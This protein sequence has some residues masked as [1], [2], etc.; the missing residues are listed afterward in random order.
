MSDPFVRLYENLVGR[1]D[2]PMQFRLM[3]QPLMA[4]IYAIKSGLNDARNGEP[5]YFWALF[6]NPDHRRAML[7]DG[8]K[9]IRN[10]FIFAIVMDLI[11]QLIAQRTFYPGE[12]VIV[13][14]I[15]AVIPYLIV[16]GPANLILRHFVTRRAPVGGQQ[17]AAAVHEEAVGTGKE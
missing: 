16:R 12:A 6:T 5:P 8:W 13:A 3:M 11:Y 2:G 7:R 15:L 1:L 10:T 4:S 17:S 9:S 14:I